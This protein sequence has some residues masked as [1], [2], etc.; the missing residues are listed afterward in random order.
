MKRDFPTFSEDASAVLDFARCQRP[1]GSVYGTS[2][3]CRKGTPVADEGKKFTPEQRKA[4]AERGEKRAAELQAKAAPAKS[5][6]K[7]EVGEK[8]LYRLMQKQSAISERLG[9]ERGFLSKMDQ[10]PKFAA[11]RKQREERITKLEKTWKK[12]EEL[13]L[14]ANKRLD[15]KAKE[16]GVLRPLIAPNWG[17]PPGQSRRG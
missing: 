4:I 9:K 12:I 8:Q 2:G 7:P 6:A 1:D 10:G 14:Q 5:K 3:Q 15:K 17:T 13:K 16:A 11:Q